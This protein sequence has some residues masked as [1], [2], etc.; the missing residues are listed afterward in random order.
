MDDYFSNY[1]KELDGQHRKI[2]EELKT[3]KEQLKQLETEYYNFS[4]SKRDSLARQLYALESSPQ[5]DNEAIERI[6]EELNSLPSREEL[7]VRITQ[8]KQE[9]EELQ[10]KFSSLPFEV[11]PMQITPYIIYQLENGCWL[12]KPLNEKGEPYG[13]YLYKTELGRMATPNFKVTCNQEDVPIEMEWLLQGSATYG[14][15]LKFKRKLVLRQPINENLVPKIIEKE[16][17]RYVEKKV[18]I[19]KF[20]PSMQCLCGWNLTDQ[21]RM[22]FCPNCARSLYDI[23]K[24]QIEQENKP[25]LK[26]NNKKKKKWF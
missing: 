11:P 10:N 15:P 22:V 26:N 19:E 1:I 23:I 18:P 8:L 4:G 9:I 7:E 25:V 2:L 14:L 12:E 13:E 20:I 5:K 21:L 17:P 16:V 24:W 3:K 6:R